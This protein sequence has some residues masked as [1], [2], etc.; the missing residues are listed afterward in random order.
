MKC[1]FSQKALFLLIPDTP[2]SVAEITSLFAQEGISITNIRIIETRED[3]YGV[4][5][6]SFQNEDDRLRAANCIA[7]NTAYETI[8]T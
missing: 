6:V 7:K 5:V 2:G 3:I 8:L 1:L 4:L